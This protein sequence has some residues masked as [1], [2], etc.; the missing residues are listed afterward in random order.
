VCVCERETERERERDIDRNGEDPF[1]VWKAILVVK[2]I[3]GSADHSGKGNRRPNDA[4]ASLRAEPH[5]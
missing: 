2:Q 3:I 5:S 4:A 1:S